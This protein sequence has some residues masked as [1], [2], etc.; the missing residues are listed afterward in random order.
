[1]QDNILNKYDATGNVLRCYTVTFEDKLGTLYPINL[2]AANKRHAVETG[3]NS[4]KEMNKKNT[5]LPIDIK[6]HDEE[7]DIITIKSIG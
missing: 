5:F 3:M 2:I 4:L 7:N 1:M 6:I